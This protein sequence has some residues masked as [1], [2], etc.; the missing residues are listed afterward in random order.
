MNVYTS[1]VG[2]AAEPR[3]SDLI[4]DL[5]H[6]GRIDYLTLGADDI[7]RRR[8]RAITD[9]GEECGI[10]LDRDAQL[11]DGAVLR[12]GHNSALVVR[13][14]NTAWLTLVPRD[15]GAALELGYFSGNMHW[16]VQFDGPV[17]KIALK[18][19]A[20]DY[21][22]RLQPF[23]ESGRAVVVHETPPHPAAHA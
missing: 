2:S 11:F 3:I 5:E 8:L 12:L 15:T 20:D 21:L 19:T 4:H 9:G 16:K 18:G 10:A 23:I 13:T 17:L 6:H 14:K 1:I 22:A 7:Q